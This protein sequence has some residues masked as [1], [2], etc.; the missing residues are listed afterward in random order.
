MS[1]RVFQGRCDQWRERFRC[2]RTRTAIALRRLALSRRSAWRRARWV[3]LGLAAAPVAWASL[4][5]LAAWVERL[6]ALMGGNAL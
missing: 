1:T 4:G 5:A 6:C 2:G 3:L